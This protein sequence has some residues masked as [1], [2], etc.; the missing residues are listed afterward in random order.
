VVANGFRVIHETHDD[1]LSRDGMYDEVY[2]A[3]AMFQYNRKTSLQVG[4]DLK[5][6]LKHGDVKGRPDRVQAG[7]ASG[8]GGLRAGD[9]FPAVADPSQRYGAALKSSSFPLQVWQGTLTEGLESVLILPTMWESDENSASFVSWFPNE[10]T[11]APRIWADL[12]VQQAITTKSLGLVTLT[13]SMVTT[14]GPTSTGA[15]VAMFATAGASLLFSGSWDRPIGLQESGPAPVL[16]RRVIVLT[17]EIIENAFA[18]S[19]GVSSVKIA[20]PL[21]DAPRP[22]LQ[23]NYVLYIQVER[24]P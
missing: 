4:F 5:Q 10:M 12:A 13:G 16:P 6:T 20:V 2:A 15:A 8:T 11:S 7:T 17:R 3:F 9:V 23:G 14:G 18:S 1:V 19:G 24:Y 22:D 21:V